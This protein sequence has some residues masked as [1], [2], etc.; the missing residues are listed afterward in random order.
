MSMLS[1][2]R[3]WIALACAGIAIAQAQAAPGIWRCGNS[4]SD[5][6]CADGKPIETDEPP[7]AERRRQADEA[8][9][10]DTEAANRMQRERLRL[11]ASQAHQRAIV[12]GPAAPREAPTDAK[13]GKKKKEKR[14]TPS[15]AF[16]ASYANPDLKE[17]KK[18]KPRAPADGD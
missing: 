8:T 2:R 3:H 12:I 9:R 1:L 5:K 6:P 4:Y 18:K 14:P 16:V 17:K 10:R 15:D 7:G 11:E 13:P